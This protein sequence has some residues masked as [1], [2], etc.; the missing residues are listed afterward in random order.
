M[1]FPYIF[2]SSLSFIV[3]LAYQ[4]EKDIAFKFIIEYSSLKDF[5]LYVINNRSIF[6]WG[7]LKDDILACVE[8]WD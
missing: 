3:G 1:F 6:I 2:L 4:G 8:T 5:G 7:F